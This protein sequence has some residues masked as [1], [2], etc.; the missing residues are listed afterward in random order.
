[1][2]IAVGTGMTPA[3]V[4]RVPLDVKG[5]GFIRCSGAGR[6]R[7]EYSFARDSICGYGAWGGSRVRSMIEHLSKNDTYTIIL[8]DGI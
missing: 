6:P 7:A 4:N 3:E 2:V 5:G 1:M 8:T